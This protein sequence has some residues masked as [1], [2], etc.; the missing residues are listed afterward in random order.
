MGSL[1]RGKS[2]KSEIS[3]A[4]GKTKEEA[5]LVK[6]K[7]KEF[8]SGKSKEFASGKSKE[9]AS[10]KSKE[11]MGAMKPEAKE[12]LRR[13]KSKEVH[14]AVPVKNKSKEDVH[15]A[16][17]AAAEAAEVAAEEADAEAEAAAAALKKLEQGEVG[18]AQAPG[19]CIGNRLS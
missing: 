8:A 3:L 9:L 10:G 1:A 16:A 7:S 6:G 14:S 11:D 2:S 15:A 13:G 19:L 5:A 12:D 4:R 18:P 17:M